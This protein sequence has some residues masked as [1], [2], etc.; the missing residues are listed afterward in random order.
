[1]LSCGRLWCGTRGQQ[2]PYLVRAVLL[3]SFALGF[4]DLTDQCY[5]GVS[6]SPSAP[7]AVTHSSGLP[8]ADFYFSLGWGLGVRVLGLQVL[9]P[10]GVL[11]W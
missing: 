2:G 8:T 7:A 9:P 4:V 5:V 6:V 3:S 1:M 10:P 11:T